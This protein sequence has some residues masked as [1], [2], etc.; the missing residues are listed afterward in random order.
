MTRIVSGIALLAIVLARPARAEQQHGQLDGSETL[1]T[2]MAALNAGGYDYEL[3]SPANHPL[4][5]QVRKELAAKKLAVMDDL[6]YFMRKHHKDNPAAELSQYI[7]F[8]LSLKG[9]P[10]FD[11]RFRTIDLPPDVE[12]MDGFSDILVRFYREA[13][14]EE[15]WNRVQPA[16]DEVLEKYHEPVS[17]AIL[18]VNGYLRNATSGYLGRRFQIYL[19]LLAPPGTRS[20]FEAMP[21]I[22]WW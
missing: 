18:Q 11:Y 21:M 15:L 6:H 19:E 14:I 16:Y 10:D 5:S 7:S 9:P 3:N 1:F 22:S 8:A 12:A 20:R 2:V 13:D 4:R 17:Q